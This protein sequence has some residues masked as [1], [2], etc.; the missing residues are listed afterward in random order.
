MDVQAVQK[1]I[2]IVNLG[3]RNVYGVYINVESLW[4][5][6]YSGQTKLGTL[7]PNRSDISGIAWLLEVN[8]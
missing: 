8:I 7:T 3:A 2:A 6:V 5:S 1:A 4:S